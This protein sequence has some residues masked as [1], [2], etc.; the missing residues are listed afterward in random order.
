MDHRIPSMYNPTLSPP[1]QS[2]NARQTGSPA[3][4]VCC[5]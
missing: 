5:D 2:M 1:K 4:E 3:P